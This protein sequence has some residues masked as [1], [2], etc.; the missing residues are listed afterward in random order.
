M[1]T[2]FLTSVGNNADLLACSASEKNWLVQ[3]DK[4][5]LKRADVPNARGDFSNTYQIIWI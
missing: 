5:A 4:I 2:T 1:A 3:D